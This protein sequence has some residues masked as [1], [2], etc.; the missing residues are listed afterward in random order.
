LGSAKEVRS[1]ESLM[2]ALQVFLKDNQQL[3]AQIEAQVF[4]LQV[5]T[6]F[7]LVK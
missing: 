2:E 1:A 4:R 7:K 5:K 6:P 3:R